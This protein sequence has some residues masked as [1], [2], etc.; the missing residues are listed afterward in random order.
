MQQLTENP[1]T[2]VLT[3]IAAGR[4]AAD[5]STLHAR[6]SRIPGRQQRPPARE[7]TLTRC[8]PPYRNQGRAIREQPTPLRRREAQP[9]ERDALPAGTR[10]DKF[11]I[12]QVLGAGGF[13]IV[14]LALDHTLERHVAIK[15]YMPSALAARGHGALGVVLRS[16][17]NAPTF[18]LG[19]RSFINEARLLAGFDHPSLVKVHQFWEAHGTAYMVM[20]YYRG[21]T[22]NSERR[23]MHGPPCEAWLRGIVDPLL[24]ALEVLH[25]QEVFHRD[26]SPDNIIVLPG[27][28]PVLLDFGAARRVV[29][30]H[31]QSLTAILKPDFAPVEQYADVPNMRQ[32]A[33]TDLYALGAVVY[34]MLKGAPPVRAVT[35]AVHDET[36][37]LAQQAGAALSGVSER[38]LGAIDWALAIAPQD[39]P[40]SVQA[41]RDALDGKVVPAR[42]R[43]TPKPNLHSGCRGPGTG[44]GVDHDPSAS[45]S[46]CADSAGS[47]LSRGIHAIAR[48]RPRPGAH[49]STGVS[50]HGGVDRAG[51]SERAGARCMEAERARDAKA[52]RIGRRGSQAVEGAAEHER[53]ATGPATASREI[54]R[55]GPAG[56]VRG[57]QLLHPTG[58][59]EPAMQGAAVRTARCM[60]SVAARGGEALASSNGSIAVGVL[61]PWPTRAVR[62]ESLS[63]AS[64]WA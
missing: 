14:Y 52:R 13:G 8:R 5:A 18:E 24:S 44:P 3:Y 35:R 37:A 31:P 60:R 33:W 23:A 34:F 29:A 39:R 22:L 40:Q 53:A 28:Q 63:T 26:I 55:S 50:S 11:E 15:E 54:E 45:W 16:A 27:G 6:R 48:R 47:D 36:P 25:K 49:G 4:W 10:L 64:S 21:R 30:D 7:A 38:F 56:R 57:S 32:G 2:C 1:A 46:L 59:H 12:L 51:F 20:P 41:L 43:A 9:I 58:V 19:L 42:D 17:S 61:R 62:R